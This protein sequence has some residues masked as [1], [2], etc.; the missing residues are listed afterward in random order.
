M[1][2]QNNTLI[3]EREEIKNLITG[4]DTIRM[5]RIKFIE[6]RLY[7]ERT[8]FKVY[9][10][11]TGALAAATFNGNVESKRLGKWRDAMRKELGSQERQE[12][13]LQ[14]MA[15]FGSLT[16]ECLVR[17]HQ[18]GKLD[19]KEEQDYAFEFFNQSAINNGITP[20]YN[21]TRKQVFDYCKAAASLLQF[22]YDN[23]VKIYSIEGMCKD[24]ELE[25]ATPLDFVCRIKKEKK[26]EVDVSLNIKTSEQFSDSHREQV[27]VEKYLW[28]RTYPDLHIEKTGL[29]RAKDWSQKK[30]LPTY[31]MELL[32]E[33][34]ETELLTDTLNRLR[35]CKASKK[36]T[37]V[38][39]EKETPVFTGITV[40]GEPP[41]IEMKT[42]EQL[43]TE[44][45]LKEE[46]V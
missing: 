42:L 15:D 8:P 27:A 10:G 6:R 35:I 1:Q 13:Y 44:I 37:Y 32:D 24:E 38:N 18:N 28:N 5:E 19:W 20:N 46:V 11:L 3:S 34:T 26:G 22:V 21:V 12:A 41:K 9:S 16:H 43:L 23:V 30:G 31:E 7:I 25:I 39:Y 17:I 29:L 36:A 4:F 40:A 45:E 2:T 14:M 33:A